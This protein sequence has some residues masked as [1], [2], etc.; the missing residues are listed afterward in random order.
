MFW[1]NAIPTPAFQCRHRLATLMLDED[2]A[3]ANC[4]VVLSQAAIDNVINGYSSSFTIESS[5]RKSPDSVPKTIQY[6]GWFSPMP[7]DEG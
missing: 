5:R 1:L 3:A 6:A 4:P 7:V 2:I